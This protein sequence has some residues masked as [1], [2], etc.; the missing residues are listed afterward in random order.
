MKISAT[1]FLSLLCMVSSE[2][3]CSLYQMANTSYFVFSQYGF[4]CVRPGQ[5]RSICRM[6]RLVG[7]DLRTLKIQN[8]DNW[9]A[10]KVL[11]ANVTHLLVLRYDGGSKRDDVMWT[12]VDVRGVQCPGRHNYPKFSA[13]FGSTHEPVLY[14]VPKTE[15]FKD[16][17]NGP[18]CVPKHA[19]MS[20]DGQRFVIADVEYD[21]TYNGRFIK[22]EPENFQHLPFPENCSEW[23]EYNK[24]Q[25]VRYE[26]RNIGKDR[27]CQSWVDENKID[28][29]PYDATVR[30]LSTEFGYVG[31]RNFDKIRKGTIYSN[32]YNHNLIRNEPLEG[33]KFYQAHYM[34][35]KPSA[36]KSVDKAIKE[37]QKEVLISPD[38]YDQCRL[39]QFRTS[40]RD[41]GEIPASILIEH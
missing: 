33:N 15:R 20:P 3:L 23:P 11:R 21:Y 14:D 4:V 1:V 19:K 28:F 7:E 36:R 8:G 26:L 25:L 40:H 10:V 34:T 30:D 18:L 29:D 35:L 32:L 16:H 37:G 31:F 24:R 22:N 9:N 5:Y 13:K 12:S 27:V 38:M 17:Y 6:N 39:R 2:R 41:A